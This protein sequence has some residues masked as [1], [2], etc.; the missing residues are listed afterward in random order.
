MDNFINW[1]YFA[2]AA[3]VVSLSVALYLYFWVIKQEPG[4]ERAQEVA[5]WI[6]EGANAYLVK[7]YRASVS[8]H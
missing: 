3:G 6:K 7:L 1:I 8:W 4:T 5:S 2:I